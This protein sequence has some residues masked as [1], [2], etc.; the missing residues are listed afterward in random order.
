MKQVKERPLLMIVDGHSTHVNLQAR[1]LARENNV[2]ILKLPSHTSDR[3]QPLDINC[4]SPLK[5]N[6][7]KKLISRQRKNDFHVLSKSDL[8]DLVC[9]VWHRSLTPSNI[10]AGFLKSGIFPVDRSKYPL[11]IFN[12]IKLN[13]YQAQIRDSHQIP[14]ASNSRLV[15]AHLQPVAIQGTLTPSKS[16]SG[17]IPKIS[18]SLQ[19]ISLRENV[20]CTVFCITLCMH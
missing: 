6:W 17:S 16:S 19:E 4:F 5:N 15:E 20:K 1:K 3:L 13:S 8:V 10:K 12:P 7:N 14:C 2:S 11:G 9:S 18:P